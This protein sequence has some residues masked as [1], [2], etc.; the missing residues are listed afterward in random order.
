MSEW[1]IFK[2][3]WKI[4]DEFLLVDDE[5][6]KF[7]DPNYSG[8]REN[9]IDKTY[10]VVKSST[11][12]TKETRGRK[13]KFNGLDTSLIRIPSDYKGFIESLSKNLSVGEIEKAKKEF[14]QFCNEI[15]K[16]EI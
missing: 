13:R 7:Y 8:K 10:K 4:K 14:E 1:K 16:G 9:K 5:V 12:K 6:L 11:K 2:N 15:E 3:W